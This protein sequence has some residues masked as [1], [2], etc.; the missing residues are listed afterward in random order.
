MNHLKIPAIAAGF[1]MLVNAVDAYAQC[2]YGTSQ[3]D[4]QHQQRDAQAAR[5]AE[6]EHRRQMEAQGDAPSY[7]NGYAAPASSGPPRPAYGFVAV[8]WHSDA[9]DVW[10]T[11][12]RSTEE[13]A[14]TVVLAA[15]RRTMG[16]GCTIALSAWNSTIA[17]AKAPDGGLK[18]GWGAE[19]KEAAERAMEDCSRYLAGCSIKHR[20]TAKPWSVAADYLP[21]DVSRLSY[22]MIGWPKSRPA[23]IWFNKVWI[24]TGQGGYERS[25]TLL[26]ERCKKDTGV[27]CQIAHIAMADSG[28]KSGGMIGSYYNPKRGTMWFASA[29]PRDAKAAMERDCR[30]DGLTCESLTTYDVFTPRLQTLDQAPPR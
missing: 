5:D 1:L 23:P 10:A 21:H 26:L 20:F 27:D 22:A 6:Q 25:S 16:E 19:P 30:A 28:T 17:V 13:E 3:Q 7:D 29:S 15:C 11:W 9:T 12:N 24:A 4:C 14:T 8:A 18:V 2:G